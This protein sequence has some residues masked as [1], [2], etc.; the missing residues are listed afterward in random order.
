MACKEGS[1]CDDPVSLVVGAARDHIP[2]D[3]SVP[4]HSATTGLPDPHTIPDPKDRASIEAVITE[5][6]SSDEYRSQVVGRRIFEAREAVY[7]QSPGS[8]TCKF[9]KAHIF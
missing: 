8:I 9:C 1:G 3:P 6:E 5:I 7:C 4:L 2:L